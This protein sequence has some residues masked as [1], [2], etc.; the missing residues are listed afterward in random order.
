MLIGIKEEKKLIKVK[1]KMEEKAE[2][3]REKDGKGV[4][5]INIDT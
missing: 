2:M 3:S 1:S 5:K 4:N